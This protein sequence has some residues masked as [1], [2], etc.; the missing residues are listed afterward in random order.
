MK[1]NYRQIISFILA[2][3]LM[4]L[5]GCDNILTPPRHNDGAGAVQ[6]TVNG[7]SSGARTLGPEVNSSI[8]PQ[9]DFSFSG[10][11][12]HA[13]ETLTSGTSTTV[14][15][16]SPGVWTITATA[17]TDM[18]STAVGKG[19]VNVTVSPGVTV[20]ADI[21]ITPIVG[22]GDG[23]L[24]YSVNI[25]EAESAVLTLIDIAT[26]DPAPN[27]PVDL[28]TSTSGILN[29]LPSGYY[30]LNISL[31]SGGTYAGRTEVVHIY[32][33]LTTSAVYP[34]TSNDFSAVIPLSDGVWRNEATMTV[35]GDAYYSFPVTAG[36]DYAVSWNDSYDGDDSKSL[37]I[38]VSAQYETGGTPI[39]TGVDF[40]YTTPQ[41]FTAAATD[42]VIIMVEP[43]SPGDTGTYGVL[44]GAVTE[45][46]A[47]WQ[48]ATIS[49]AGA[50]FYGFDATAATPYVIAWDDVPDGSG[51]TGDIQVGA[52]YGTTNLFSNIDSGYTEPQLVSI[53]SSEKVFIRVEAK[54]G[55]AGSY[56]LQYGT[57]PVIP[58]SD[59]IPQVESIR[60]GELKLYRF[61][62]D[63]TKVYAVSWEASRDQ[64][65][66]SS[67]NGDIVVT[68]YRGSIGNL[69][70][71]FDGV[72]HGYSEPLTV[73]SPYS[74]V[75]YLKL[76]IKA[77]G[78]AGTYAIQY[79]EVVSPVIL[80]DGVWQDDT[81]V[82]SGYAYY[83]F[84][85][86]A[87][88]DYA[89]SWNSSYKGDGS[90][91][92]DIKVSAYYETDRTPIFTGVDSGG[93]TT[94][95]SFTA[96]STGNVIIRV[97]PYSFGNIGTYGVK[98]TRR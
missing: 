85:V 96:I 82:V 83:S 64:D 34:F 81:M 5:A 13:N 36:Q 46:S 72:D 1:K 38:K 4:V 84:P 45:L 30:L 3:A 33:G 44:Y 27:T 95:Q 92:L 31:E 75:I 42:T 50:A 88:R 80:S 35:S 25:L 67:Y 19:T 20:P 77:G 98:Y 59:G 23:S 21:V 18:G 91:T 61:N 54:E 58:L 2:A 11:G 24:D 57:V 17:Y 37:D 29:S 73:D 10:P 97:E 8:F 12:S 89:V 78:S 40:G 51:Q 68:G 60:P 47:D 49:A 41:I 52:W 55:A 87:G 28:K 79:A 93:Y 26:E 43:S 62:T 9:Y 7:G 14:G 76:G 16:L 48:S 94:P 63:V 74:A 56:R 22:A 39:F 6:I 70:P 53:S 86:T 66:F 71:I 90:K 69:P 32:A 15:S 65:G